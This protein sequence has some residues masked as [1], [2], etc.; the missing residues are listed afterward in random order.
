MR[1]L[2][3]RLRSRRVEPRLETGAARSISLGEVVRVQGRQVMHSRTWAGGGWSSVTTSTAATTTTSRRRGRS[4]RHLADIDDPPRRSPRRAPCVSSRATTRVCGFP[5]AGRGRVSVNAQKDY[6]SHVVHDHTSILSLIE[7]KWN[8]PALTNR[9]GAAD[10]LLDS[11]DLTAPPAFLKPPT[12]PAA[13][14]PRARARAARSTGRSDRATELLR[15]A[16]YTPPSGS[17]RT[18][19]C[20]KP[21]ATTTAPEPTAPDQGSGSKNRTV[22]YSHDVTN[23]ARRAGRWRSSGAPSS[24][25]A[26]T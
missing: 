24:G 26:P 1:R 17:T 22:R 12:L 3:R 6:V 16:A 10:N 14:E 25:R 11:L 23:Y 2:V 13:D 8:L 5:S 4:R 18:A 19:S 21:S 15:P 9:D 20:S 7:H